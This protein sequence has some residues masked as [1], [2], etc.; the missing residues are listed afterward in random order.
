MELRTIATFLQIVESGSFSG[1]AAKLGY[2]QSAVTMQVKQLEAELGAVLFDRMPRGVALTQ[3]GRRFAFY[4]HE[5]ADAVERAQAATRG[6]AA[7]A[8]DNEQLNGVL[9][10]GAVESIATA[11]LP[12]LLE[13]FLE[14]HPGVEVVV[15]AGRCESLI[16]Q[17]RSNA[18]DLFITMEP[19]RAARDLER[20][21]LSEEQVIFVAT[22]ELAARL[23]PFS[24][25]RLGATPLVLT[26]RGESYRAELE[27]V[28]ARLDIELHPVVE[29]GNTEMLTQLARR[30]VGAAFLP[31]PCVE[32]ELTEGSL[33][34]LTPTCSNERERQDFE[35]R[36]RMAI[37]LFRHK[38]KAVDPRMQAFI[39]LAQDH[40]FTGR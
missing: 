9:R 10:I 25:D 4:A 27:H 30:G 14:A 11:V 22:P 18:L 23:H 21:I 12:S 15:Q 24:L 19:P 8:Q 6:E 34:E 35:R 2:T 1:A 28:L 13:S 36:A 38:G 39:T 3:E 17:L 40:F 29:A 31:R 32:R 20:I 37:Q 16:E 5:V 7:N 33:V 26:E